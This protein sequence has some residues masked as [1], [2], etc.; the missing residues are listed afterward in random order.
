TGEPLTIH[1]GLDDT[2][3][4]ALSQFGWR[5]LLPENERVEFSAPSGQDGEISS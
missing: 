2:W 3:M 4:Q 5:G 1:A